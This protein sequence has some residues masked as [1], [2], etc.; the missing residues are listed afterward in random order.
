MHETDLYM[1]ISQF[2]ASGFPQR[3][4]AS[5]AWRQVSPPSRGTMSKNDDEEEKDDDAI[6]TTT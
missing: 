5:M 6:S 4:Q 3:E 1:K 2:P